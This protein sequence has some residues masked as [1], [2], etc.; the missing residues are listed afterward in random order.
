MRL[1]ILGGRNFKEV[2]RDRLGLGFLLG[3]P[4]L[5][6]LIIGLAW[7]RGGVQPLPVAVVDEDQSPISA[8]FVQVLK[9]APTWKITVYPSLSQAEHQVKQSK[10]V[11]YILIPEGFG[12]AVSLKQ[13]GGEGKIPLAMGYDETQPGFGP[14]LHSTLSSIALAFFQIDLPLALEVRAGIRAVDNPVMNWIAPSLI[15]LGLMILI[16]TAAGRLVRDRQSG[17]LARLLTT[18]ARPWDFILGY[19][20]PF[21]LVGIMLVPLYLVV[22]LLLGLEILGS[23]PLAFLLYFLVATV[24][25]GISMVIASLARTPEQ[26]EGGSWLLI[27]P[28]AAISGVWFPTEQMPGYIRG[29]ASIFPFK[30]AAEASREIINRAGGWEAVGGDFLFILGW[31]VAAFALGVILF[32]RQM[33]R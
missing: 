3:M 28:L 14:A 10:E 22:A 24:C 1:W 16:P 11:G 26:V 7:G 5:F 19:S 25:V 29:L 15:I 33:A 12:K 30:Y 20:L 4:I 32:R 17:F 13:Q 31:T 6:M 21:V 27:M 8:A 23:L 2:R 18:P 9:Q